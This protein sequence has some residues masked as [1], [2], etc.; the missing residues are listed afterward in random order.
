LLFL[1]SQLSDQTEE[2]KL[3]AI[4]WKIKEKEEER[5]LLLRMS[6]SI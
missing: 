4:D 3:K 2:E 1:P 5:Q 6:E